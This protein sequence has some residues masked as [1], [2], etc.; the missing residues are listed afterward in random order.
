MACPIKLVLKVTT[1]GERAESGRNVSV[2]SH[3]ASR[4]TL[5]WVQAIRRIINHQSETHFHRAIYTGAPPVQSWPQLPETA[6]FPD[7][8]SEVASVPDDICELM[9]GN[10]FGAK[11]YATLKLVVINSAPL[12]M[13]SAEMRSPGTWQ[14]RMNL[15]VWQYKISNGRRAMEAGSKR[16][17]CKAEQQSHKCSITRQFVPLTTVHWLTCLYKD[18]TLN[19]D[20]HLDKR[21][22][23]I[24]YQ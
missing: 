21:M 7:V 12:I 18:Y 8:Y 11:P 23:H 24:D 9:G 2:P 1:R 20:V 6:Q 13:L 16:L 3:P 19:G 22:E 4:G 5:T 15:D 17:G 14:C 10:R